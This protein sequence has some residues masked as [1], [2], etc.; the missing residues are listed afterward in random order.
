MSKKIRDGQLGKQFD[1]SVYLTDFCNEGDQQER[2]SKVY[3][4]NQKR[5]DCTAQQVP[6]HSKP[7][8]GLELMSSEAKEPGGLLTFTSLTL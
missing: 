6:L 2:F 1:Y 4:N 7:F 8:L 3:T 5:I